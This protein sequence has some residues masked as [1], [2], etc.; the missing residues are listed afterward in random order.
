MDLLLE[1]NGIVG[2][3]SGSIPYPDK[4]ADSDSE[5]ETIDNNHH[6]SDA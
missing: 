5:K 2:F 6:V 1:G 3:V 4:F